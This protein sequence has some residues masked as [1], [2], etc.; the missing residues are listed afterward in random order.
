MKRIS[1]ILLS[2]VTSLGV[3]GCGGD[4]NTPGDDEPGSD[5]PNNPTDEWDK[6]L[7]KREFDY[8]AALRIAALR[9]TGELPT[10]TEILQ[11]KDAGDLAAQKVA[12]EALV[13]NYMGRPTFAR[14]MRAFWRDTFRMG[15]TAEMDTAPTFAA[16]LS[17][18]NRDYTELFKAATGACPT[19]DEATGVFTPADCAGAG[20]K[21]G[22][23][24]NQGAMKLYFGNFA[25]RRVKWVQETFDCTKFPIDQTGAPQNVGGTVPFTGS[26]PFE[27]ISGKDNGGRVDFHDVASIICANCHVNLN[28]QAPLFANYDENGAFQP[29]I[30]VRTP[31]PNEPLAVASDFLPP[32]EPTAWRA[33]LV[34]P[35]LVSY[36]QAM[37]ADPDIAKCAVGRFWNWSLGK[38][39]IVDALLDVPPETIQAQVD[40]FTQSGFKTKDLI[41]MVFT[42]D[43][44]VKF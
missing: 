6:E 4:S 34:T 28:H 13:T 3:L 42:A 7:A 41:Y 35:D 1:I 18:E 17:V 21:V 15:E 44:F 10:M 8:N 2:A 19:L 40:A 14:Q 23:L 22:V 20:P 5:D 38:A 37:A 26:F 27:S 33:G 24:T 29:N 9:L 30:A 11:V 12:Y 32:G 36:G 31:L 16:Q 43:D 25:F 39:D